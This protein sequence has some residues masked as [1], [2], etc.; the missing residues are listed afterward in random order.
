MDPSEERMARYM[1][2]VSEQ[3]NSLSAHMKRELDD[4]ILCMN[5]LRQANRPARVQARVL[6][7]GTVQLITG[8][9]V[10]GI[11][12]ESQPGAV[13]ITTAGP[14]VQGRVLPDGTVMVGDNELEG[15]RGSPR[16][17][18]TTA[19]ADEVEKRVKDA[20]QDERLSQLEERR[21][22]LKVR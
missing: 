17:P 18:E 16:E 1:T 13:R 10:D 19:E 14:H 7:D 22:Y 2:G 3:I 15:I 20:V 12:G 9:I 4:L 21:E 5:D 11:R 8:E 6:S